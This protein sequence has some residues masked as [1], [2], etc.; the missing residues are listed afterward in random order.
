MHIQGFPC[1]KGL[2]PEHFRNFTLNFLDAFKVKTFIIVNQNLDQ[3][4]I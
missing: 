3:Q 1:V 4:T 2:V